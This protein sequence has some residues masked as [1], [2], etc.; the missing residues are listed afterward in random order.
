MAKKNG[1]GPSKVTASSA[2][3]S[4][5]R[6]LL[7]DDETI[8]DARVKDAVFCPTVDGQPKGHGLVPRDYRT[9]PA[10]MFAAP[11][12]DMKLIPTA[13]YADRVKDQA[14]Q[15]SS[16]EDMIDWPSLDQNGQGFCWMYSTTGVVMAVR[17]VNNL[18]YVR[19]SAHA[20]ACKVKN[21]RDEGG[22]CGLSAKFYREVGCPSVAFWPEKSMS[23]SY[24][25]PEV[26]A[27]GALHKIAEDWVD[28]TRDVYD[29]QLTLQQL[30]TCLLCNVPC[31]TDFNW[32]SHSV[33]MG[34]LVQV[35]AGS[36]GR[37]IRNSWTDSWGE[38]GWSTLRGSKAVPDS[39][40][41]VRASVLSA[42]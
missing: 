42:A 37:R 24:D 16:L 10:Q 14:D 22:W 17:T 11:P 18:P 8:N 35:E 21:F 31:A 7:I 23:R 5:T 26:W 36:F 20:G 15:K 39:A 28:L 6:G 25:K 30:D 33:F 4:V 2:G 32:W 19:L 1:S 9:F 3:A 40:L 41:A 29:Q 13:E 34:R 12:A 38:K 27:N